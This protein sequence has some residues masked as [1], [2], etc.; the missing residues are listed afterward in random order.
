MEPPSIQLARALFTLNFLNC[1]FEVLNPPIVHHFGANH[2]LTIKEKPPVMVKN[3]EKGKMEG[4]HELVTWGL[5]YT[6]MSTP[7]GPKWL[8]S[9]WV[10]PYAPK[11]SGKKGITLPQVT[12]TAWRQ[13]CKEESAWKELP[14]PSGP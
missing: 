12:Q 11:V 1:S 7:K 8:P 6:C 10:R 5:G 9:K 13:K 4:S 14:F 3:P 2:Q